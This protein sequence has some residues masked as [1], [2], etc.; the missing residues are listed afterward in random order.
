MSKQE[1]RQRF[2]AQVKAE[3]EM[4][5]I[6]REQQ[7]LEYEQMY[8]T[9]PSMYQYETAAAM[10]ADPNMAAG[11]AEQN[12]GATGSD[13]LWKKIKL[14]YKRQFLENINILYEIKKSNRV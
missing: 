9:D 13:K 3:E 12:P 6:Q 8:A 5:K 2:E 10:F 11:L 14:R 1:R 4:A 7:E